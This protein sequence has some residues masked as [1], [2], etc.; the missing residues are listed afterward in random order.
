MVSDPVPV[1]LSRI[2]ALHMSFYFSEVSPIAG[3]AEH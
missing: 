1:S 3:E 2:H